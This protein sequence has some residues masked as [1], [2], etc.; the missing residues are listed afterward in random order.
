MNR[1]PQYNPIIPNASRTPHLLPP[2]NGSGLLQR[3]P[4]PHPGAGG[5]QLI[6]GP[7]LLPPP[8]QSVRPFNGRPPLNALM[9]GPPPPGVN[10]LPMIP[11]QN[12][13]MHNRMPPPPPHMMHTNASGPPS[14]MTNMSGRL[15]H[16]LPP[17]AAS[18]A[19]PPLP[20]KSHLMPNPLLPSPLMA[21]PLLPNV[22]GSSSFTKLDHMNKEMDNGSDHRLP[23]DILPPNMFSVLPNHPN[24]PPPLGQPPPGLHRPPMSIGQMPINHPP[25]PIGQRPPGFPNAGFLNQPMLIQPPPRLPTLPSNLDS[26]NNSDNKVKEE[27]DKTKEFWIETKASDSKVYYYNSRTRETSWIKPENSVILTHEQYAQQHARNLFPNGDKTSD[28]KTVMPNPGSINPL[29]QNPLG[30]GIPTP[31]WT[32]QVSYK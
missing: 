8:G 23:S 4:L 26:T 21:K 11:V 12:Q 9:P 6:G 16:L 17:S 24:M 1:Q 30:T 2:P 22:P 27:T 7:S 28:L 3:P 32:V 10:R 19:P 13:P 15:P 14:L 29:L 5:Q 18:G 25:P 31:P 20:N